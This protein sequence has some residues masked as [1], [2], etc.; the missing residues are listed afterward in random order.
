MK[1][2]YTSNFKIFFSALIL[3][4]STCFAQTNEQKKIITKDYD[5]I[6][7]KTLENKFKQSFNKDKKEAIKYAKDN[8]LPIRYS[9]ENGTLYEIK[10]IS[11]N[12]K[13]QYYKTFNNS[14]AAV[15]TRTNFLNSSSFYGYN[16]DGQ[17]MTVHVWDGGL[18]RPGH[19]EYDGTG[20]NNR[21]T[22]GDTSND[23]NFHG[24]HV[25]GTIINS[26]VDSSAKGMAPQANAFG[27][28]WNSDL[29][30]AT[31]AASNGMLLSNHSYGYRSDLIDD[32][33][34]G[35]YIQDSKDWDE[36]MYNAPYYLMVVAA[37]NDGN[38]S[39]SNGNPLNGNSQ[40]DKLSGHATS[41]N[42]LVI[43]NG[44]DANISFTGEL[45]SVSRNSSSSEGP[46]DDFRIK[47][48]LMGNGTGLLSTVAS[49]DVAY[50]VLT[51]TSMASPNVCGSLLL[52]Q[53]Y[54]NQENGDFMKS[55]TLKGL[56][57]HTADDV[58]IAGPDATTGWGLMNSKFAA[59]TI[60]KN[61][62]ESLILEDQL[63]DG[64]TFTTKIKSDGINPLVISISWTDKE[65]FYNSAFSIPNNTA[66]KLINDLDIRITKDTD[67]YHPWKLTGLDT[68]TNSIGTDNNVDPYERVDITGAS[69]IYTITISHKGTL[70]D[71][72]QNFSLIATG[73]DVAPDFVNNGLTPDL[74]ST[75]TTDSNNIEVS[76]L[77]DLVENQ[78]Y[79]IKSLP[80]IGTLLK[81]NVPLSIS[82][83]FSQDDVNNSLITFNNT[84]LS[85]F[86]DNFLVDISN[87][88]NG[89]LS[90]Q[91]IQINSTSLLSNKEF[92]VNEL[93]IYPNP[94]EDGKINIQI[95]TASNDDVNINIY[96]LLGR[97][98]FDEIYENS[99]IFKKELKVDKF[100][101]GIYLIEIQ[102]GGKKTTK[103]II[104][105]N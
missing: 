33:W 87:G 59:E 94:S 52:L 34:F 93:G 92:E 65:G 82:D 32:S 44:Q 37:G 96:D 64:E 14:D 90:D 4:S 56:A 75:Y 83:F 62:K 86:N 81:N 11:K 5:L 50:S 48:D 78:I 26:G 54:Y 72:L 74:N 31:N 36:L 69:G 7:L 104:I 84:E 25:T 1:K 79:T 105:K 60:T 61:N 28:D 3:I 99:N 23:L 88:I 70:V 57:L 89:L 58:D 19:V 46:T 10:K 41:K 13:P 91:S 39:S 17:N 27:Y 51:G 71:G 9:D 47:P 15:S 55:S 8:N 29:S 101:N 2:N 12:G 38:D 16:L 21:F 45:I 77:N 24:A 100:S 66:P 102:Q 20:G 30:E 85:Q 43:A 18:A 63:L 42:N 49:S 53:Q 68:N 98:V 40:F 76:T 6:K 103:K 80:S 95:S 73:L 97:K 22:V 35:N 67:T